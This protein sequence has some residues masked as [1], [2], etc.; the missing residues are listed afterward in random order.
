M[1]L[2]ESSILQ[3]VI[4]TSTINPPTQGLDFTPRAEYDINPETYTFLSPCILG[5]AE[6]FQKLNFNLE[7]SGKAANE[8]LKIG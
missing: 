3:H 8:R 5:W 1:I 6:K 7:Y 4:H 2:T